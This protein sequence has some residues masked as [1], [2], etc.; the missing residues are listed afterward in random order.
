MSKSYSTEANGYGRGEAVGVVV[1]RLLPEAEKCGDRIYALLLATNV[2]HDGS[3]TKPITSPSQIMHEE[4]FRRTCADA[5]LEPAAVA[6]VEDHVTGTKVGDKANVASTSAVYG[7]HAR[8]LRVGVLKPNI[9]HT[10]VWQ[11]RS[12]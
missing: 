2:N 7:N 4:L 6:Y 10:E 8:Q 11:M 12:T 1:L 5:G 9:C 3:T